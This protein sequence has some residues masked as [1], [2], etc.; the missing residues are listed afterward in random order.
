MVADV[1]SKTFNIISTSNAN[2]NLAIT[3]VVTAF[4]VLELSN[5]LVLYFKPEFRF[6]NGVGVFN[7]WE[8]SKEDTYMHSFVN[9]L[10]KWVAGSKIIFV[11]LLIVM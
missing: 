2:M 10:V 7:A 3:I 6:A 8:K 11:A 9:Y 5:I 4:L 1:S